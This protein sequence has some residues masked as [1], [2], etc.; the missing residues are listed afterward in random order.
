[1]KSFSEAHPALGCARA[2]VELHL[3][4]DGSTHVPPPDPDGADHFWLPTPPQACSWIGVPLAVAA[5]TASRH[6]P[7]WTPVIVPSV[8]TFHCWLVPPLQSQT[9]TAVPLAV[10]LPLASRHL[11]PW[12]FSC[13]PAVWVQRW[14]AWPLQSHSCARVPLAVVEAGTSRQRPEATPLI[15]PVP[16]P[17]PSAGLLGVGPEPEPRAFMTAAYAGLGLPFRSNSSGL[18]A[19]RQES[20][21]RTPHTVMP[22]HRAT[23]RQVLTALA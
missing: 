7:D 6:R 9:T 10:P 19:L 13:L 3:Y 21:S 4:V 22:V 1:M 11:S 12:I 23:D 20:L 14:L 2:P 8:W 18:S 16:L 15:S 17:V 5:P